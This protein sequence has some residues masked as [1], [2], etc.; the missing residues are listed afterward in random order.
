MNNKSWNRST[1]WF[2]KTQSA[3]GQA[4]YKTKTWLSIYTTELE[5]TKQF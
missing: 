4:K 3:L 2:G 5:I 1:I